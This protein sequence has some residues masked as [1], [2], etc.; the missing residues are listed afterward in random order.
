MKNSIQKKKPNIYKNNNF[1]K[2]LNEVGYKKLIKKAR[3]N[4]YWRVVRIGYEAF[5]KYKL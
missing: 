2:R 3:I 1:I 5:Q 4:H